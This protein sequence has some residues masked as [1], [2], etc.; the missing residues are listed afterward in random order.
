MGV[1]AAQGEYGMFQGFHEFRHVLL[2]GPDATWQCPDESAAQN[3]CH[4]TAQQGIRIAGSAGDPDMVHD[5]RDMF[6]GQFRDY[7]RSTVTGTYAGS[8]GCDD[9]VQAVAPGGEQGRSQTVRIVGQD[10]G[11]EVGSPVRSLAEV[12]QKVPDSRAASVGVNARVSPVAQRDY[13]ASEGAPAKGDCVARR[14]RTPP[15]HP[16]ENAFLGH[17]ALPNLLVNGAAVAMTLFTDLGDFKFRFA[18]DKPV[19]HG[20]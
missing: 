14:R 9:Q 7:I 18:D 8:A 19:R 12:I 17:H 2:N 4:G 13:A 1:Q 16:A 11:R 5:S 20:R 6:V 3:G 10:F 15:Y